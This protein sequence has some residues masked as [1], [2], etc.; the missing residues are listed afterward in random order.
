MTWQARMGNQ[1]L[2]AI[3]GEQPGDYRPVL[4][5]NPVQLRVTRACLV[6]LRESDMP[7]EV[8]AGAVVEVPGYVADEVVAAGRGEIILPS[9]K[10]LFWIKKVA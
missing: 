2:A 7:V 6:R 8:S 5:R 9:E 10:R 4:N 1:T 3:I